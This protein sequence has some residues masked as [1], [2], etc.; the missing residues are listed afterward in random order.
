[1]EWESLE[2]VLGTGMEDANIMY[3]GKMVLGGDSLAKVG[4]LDNCNGVVGLVK[5]CL[6]SGRVDTAMPCDVGQ[7]ANDAIIVASC[8]WMRQWSFLREL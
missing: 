4:I 8:E 3:E 6:D 2:K 5:T 1:M 7:R